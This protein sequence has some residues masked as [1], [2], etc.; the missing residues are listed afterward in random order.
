MYDVQQISILFRQVYRQQLFVQPLTTKLIKLYFAREVT[1]NDVFHLF[2]HR[3]LE[4][5]AVDAISGIDVIVV[6]FCSAPEET[7]DVIFENSESCIE[8]FENSDDGILRFDS[9]LGTLES[10]ICVEGTRK[11]VSVVLEE[12][13]LK[14]EE[15]TNLRA[16]VVMPTEEETLATM[17]PDPF[18]CFSFAVSAFLV[19][20]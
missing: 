20:T 5:V 19:A 15:K 9:T 12:E 16:F 2:T 7:R 17:V 3:W 13:E 10:A 11:G 18:M 14:E 6:N 8:I 4:G 1:S